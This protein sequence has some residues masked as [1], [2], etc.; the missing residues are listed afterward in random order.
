M[1]INCEGKLCFFLMLKKITKRY[2]TSNKNSSQL[3]GVQN[4]TNGKFV[5]ANYVY[6]KLLRFRL[7]LNI[8]NTH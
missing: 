7:P 1:N 5:G 2:E 6:R 8:S 4:V 3:F